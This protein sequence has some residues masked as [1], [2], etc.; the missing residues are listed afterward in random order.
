LICKSSSSLMCIVTSTTA[1]MQRIWH[2]INILKLL[3]GTHNSSLCISPTNTPKLYT[4]NPTPIT[5]NFCQKKKKHKMLHSVMLLHS[6]MPQSEM[7]HSLMLAGFRDAT[8]FSLPELT[9]KE[10]DC[11]FASGSLKIGFHQRMSMKFHIWKLS[12]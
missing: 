9:S 1:T 12:P 8:C 5:F 6:E 2:K 11:K 10:P 4:A 7:L 3:H